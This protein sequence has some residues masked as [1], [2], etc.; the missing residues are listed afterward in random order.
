MLKGKRLD[1][2]KIQ[3]KVNNQVLPV[4]VED[5][6]KFK[7]ICISYSDALLS[8]SSSDVEIV[9]PVRTIKLANGT[10]LFHNHQYDLDEYQKDVAYYQTFI[11]LAQTPFMCQN[12]TDRNQR[13]CNYITHDGLKEIDI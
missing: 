2:L 9:N 8:L 7:D 3:T 5:P 4:S 11:T 1:A 6:F 10:L 13:L 12:S